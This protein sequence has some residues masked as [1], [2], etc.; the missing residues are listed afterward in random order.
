MHCLFTLQAT[1][2]VIWHLTCVLQKLRSMLL[3]VRSV[4]GGRPQ[5]AIRCCWN[6]KTAAALGSG[7]A[8]AHCSLTILQGQLLTAARPPALHLEL[9]LCSS[10]S[11]DWSDQACRLVQGSGCAVGCQMSLLMH[12]AS[13]PSAEHA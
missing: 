12:K 6:L 8:L 11:L 1:G 9:K 13:T 2:R 3:L 5:T 4:E 10:G 7:A